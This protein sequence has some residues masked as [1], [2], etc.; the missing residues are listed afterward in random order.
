MLGVAD[1]QDLDV[2]ASGACKGYILCK[3]RS[4]ECLCQGN[5]EGVVDREVS[6]KIKRTRKK[7]GVRVARQGAL[8]HFLDR[9][10]CP[11]PT[12]VALKEER[13]MIGPTS[14]SNSCGAWASPSWSRRCP[15]TSS[16]NGGVFNSR[17]SIADT[18]ITINET[19]ARLER[20]RPSPLWA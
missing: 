7:R 10:T 8:L 4:V 19:C 3:Q 5:I 14:A 16:A 13:R 20:R 9:Q 1:S 12:E 11:L 6:P 17:S 2:A 18:S 15:A